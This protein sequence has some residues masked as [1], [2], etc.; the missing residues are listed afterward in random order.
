MASGPAKEEIAEI[1]KTFKN[2]HKANKVCFDCGA[3]NPTWAS[4]TFAVYICLDCSSV[5]RNMGVHITFVRS[6]NLDSWTWQQLRLMK[7][8]GNG[9]ASDFFAA[10]GGS[11]LLAPSTQGKEKYTSQVA[12]LYKEELHRRALQDA[13]GLGLNAPFA[14][15]GVAP[16]GGAKGAKGADLDFFDE[17]DAPSA[18]STAAPVAPASASVATDAASSG[19]ASPALTQTSIPAPPITETPLAQPAAAVQAPRPVTSA[20]LRGAG[21][22]AGRRPGALGAVRATNSPSLGAKP[23]KLGLGVRKTGAAANFDFDA[24]ERRVKEEQAQAAEAA[25]AAREAQQAADTAAEE[26]AQ[27]MA[28][29][30]AQEPV[31]APAPVPRVEKP[32]PKANPNVDRLGMG[33]TRLGLAQARNQA[34]L[35]K[36]A[37]AKKESLAGTLCATHVTEA[38]ET[39][40]ARS[41]FASQKCGCLTR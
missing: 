19:T 3:K 23:G 26:A 36:A 20:A 7:V 5:H 39:N 30:R 2:A 15:P 40:Y 28:A 29:T 14:I 10:H 32:S 1:F 38:E 35:K 8:G 25:R 34:A 22:G 13:A 41:K 17:W 24:A 6:T 18:S 21:A 11:A 37:D 16:S 27:R 31:A 33:F 12:A 4:A 9:A